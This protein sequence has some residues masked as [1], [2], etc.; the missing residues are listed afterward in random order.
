MYCF[1]MQYSAQRDPSLVGSTVHCCMPGTGMPQ[2]AEALFCLGSSLV[3][4]VDIFKAVS[5]F[6]LVIPFLKLY[7]KELPSQ[8]KI[9]YIKIFCYGLAKRCSLQHN[10]SFEEKFEETIQSFNNR[11]TV[12]L[13]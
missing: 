2:K 5:N 10:L 11:E 9:H 1:Q 8:I 7:L 13:W 12:K 3:V 4:Y 6:C